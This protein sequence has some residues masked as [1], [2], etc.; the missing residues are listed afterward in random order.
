MNLLRLK[1]FCSNWLCTNEGTR[2][3]GV[4]SGDCY[5]I[6]GCATKTNQQNRI[7]EIFPFIILVFSLYWTVSAQAAIPPI[8][9]STA[10]DTPLE[11]NFSQVVAASGVTNPVLQIVSSPQ[12]GSYTMGCSSS[13]DCIVY[14]PQSGFTGF[15]VFQYTVADSVNGGSEP[16][17]SVTVNVG[18]VTASNS[19]TDAV[20]NT[21]LT[22]CDASATA[23][24]D[25]F[26]SAFRAASAT[27]GQIPPDLR[28]LLNA[29]SPQDVASQGGINSDF[30]NQ[31]LSNISKHLAAL[32]QAQTSVSLGGLTLQ[33]GDKTVTG[34]ML[35]Q[36]LD[37][38][39]KSGAN[40]DDKNLPELSGGG[41]S[42]DSKG[43]FS[44]FGN[45]TVGNSSQSETEFENAFS[46]TTNGITQGIDYRLGSSGYIGFAGGYAKSN[47]TM[48]YS[49]GGL[50]AEGKNFILYGSFYLTKNSYLDLIMTSGHNH[51]NNQRRIV[52]GTED[53]Y[54]YSAND[55]SSLATKA[56]Y[57]YSLANFKGWSGNLELSAQQVKTSIQGFTEV[58]QSLYSVT[59]ADRDQVR[60]SVSLGG[61][62]T[63]AASYSRMVVIPQFDLYAIH[64][65]QADADEI[66]AYFNEDPN[67]TKFSF[68]SNVPD[69]NYIQSNVGV[70]FIS[71][72]GFTGFVQ[73]GATLSQQYYSGT[74]FSA[75]LRIEF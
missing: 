47:V 42:A 23:Q 27:P 7:R 1:F 3:I 71:P 50:D 8:N 11:I 43:Q 31:Q 73:L 41:A 37:A 60:T 53:S 61:N 56:A 64:N 21:L 32:R 39:E 70:S 2:G 57:G 13:S 14:T 72:G 44:Y 26:C 30:I 5:G 18:S 34:T 59:I 63:Y 45:G 48:D 54:A 69:S 33:Q 67:H 51:F 75:G 55:S 9:V 62:V 20:F 25:A 35:A 74:Q 12:Y 38:N 19:G 66:T 15:D 17:Q 24:L 29:I 40:A 6:S 52:F 28:E 68:L 58:S 4:T 36:W 22:I 65:L 49:Q 16:P 46:F 10:K